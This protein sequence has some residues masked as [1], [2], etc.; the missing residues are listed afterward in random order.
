[1][2]RRHPNVLLGLMLSAGLACH[3]AHP[4]GSDGGTDAGLVDAG[5]GD[6]GP[7]DAGM[8][9]AGPDDAGTPDAGTPDAGPPPVY[10]TASLGGSDCDPIVP[11]QCGYPFPSNV[12]LV[13]DP[14][15]PTGRHVRFGAA[16]LPKVNG[17][18][19]INPSAWVDSDGFSPGQAPLAHLPGATLQG[20]ATPDTF[21]DSLKPDSP[22]V[23]L[24]AFSGERVPH[25]VE[26]DVTSSDPNDQAFMIRPAARLKDATRYIVAIRN[27]VDATGQPLTPTPV[28]KALRDGVASSDPS[29]APRRALYTDILAKLKS[30]GVDAGTLQLAWDYTTASRENNTKPLAHMRDDALKQVGDLGPPYHITLVHELADAET[31]R[32]IEGTMH[33]PLYLD[34]GDV[35]TDADPTQADVDHGFRLQRGPDGLPAPNGFADVPFTVN[36]PLGVALGVMQSNEPGPILLYGH[37][38]GADRTAGLDLNDP[39]NSELIQFASLKRYVSIS[40]D[41]I[42]FTHSSVDHE[43]DDVK[44][45]QV[46]AGDIGLFRRIVD[47]AMQGIVNQI[48]AIRMMKGGFANDPNAMYVGRGLVDNTVA[49]YMGPGQ[50]GNFGVAL[51]ALSPDVSHAFLEATG[52]PYDLIVPRSTHF[53]PVLSALRQTYGNA[54]NAQLA[55]GLM[56]MHLDRIEADGFASTLAGDPSKSVLL[57][58]AID[59][60]QFPSLSAHVLARSL[61]A[62][63][64][65][66]VN[67][68]VFGLG[69]VVG[70]FKGTTLTEV[71]FQVAAMM[72]VTLPQTDTPPNGPQGSDPHDLVLSVT[73]IENQV[74]LFLRYGVA[75]N[76]CSDKCNPD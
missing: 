43:D 31:A 26:L 18:A 29:V 54:R 30:A 16:T 47:R 33:V 59:D 75:R 42:G 55:L 10:P 19:P 15:T 20:L 5:A 68:E 70:P 8:Q 60:F 63:N 3:N 57:D 12:Y 35:L 4:V 17:A 67:R 7:V 69:D 53:S 41:T 23:L 27:V 37:D 22:T 9:D 64:L 71:D 45:R 49:Y 6:A 38:V 56:Q 46:L 13:A 2:L 62:Q 34:H 72:G 36:I 44:L 73:P 61:G 52:A 32:R 66:P 51:V 21:A 58:T 14:S 65:Q 48:L 40:V 1:M 39:S 28:F 76:S 74:D 50:G 24:D 25:F 11:T